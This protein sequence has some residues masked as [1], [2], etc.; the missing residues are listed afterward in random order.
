M[1]S[2]QNGTIFQGRQR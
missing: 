1:I 2:R